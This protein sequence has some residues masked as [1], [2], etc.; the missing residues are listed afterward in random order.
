MDS[1]WIQFKEERRALKLSRYV[2][3]FLFVIFI[4]RMT[5]IADACHLKAITSDNM[6]YTTQNMVV[7]A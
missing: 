7:E 1:K 5:L 3:H 2:N 6:K 4:L